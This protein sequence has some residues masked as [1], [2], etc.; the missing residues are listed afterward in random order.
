MKLVVGLGN[1]GKEYDNTRHNMGFQQID[2]FANTHHV[3]FDREKFGGKYCEILIN[4]EKVILLKPQKYI[5][6]SGEV[7]YKFISVIEEIKRMKYNLEKSYHEEM[8]KRR[9]PSAYNRNKF[10][11]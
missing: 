11:I 3:T 4:N 8:N 6:L 7:I 9:D 1:P 2:L 5:N 10:M